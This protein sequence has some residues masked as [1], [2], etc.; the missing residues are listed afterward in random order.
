[1]E[2]TKAAP[3]YLPLTF[4]FAEEPPAAG[5]IE[6]QS[7][8][9][10]ECWVGLPPGRIGRATIEQT[11]A[12]SLPI[13]VGAFQGQET[14]FACIRRSKDAARRG[15]LYQRLIRAH[16]MPCNL[17]LEEQTVGAL[18]FGAG[19]GDLLLFDVAPRDVREA[20]LE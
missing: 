4:N 16:R 13:Y 17:Q 10:I 11:D 6:G 7:S 9:R 12:L 3:D 2:R 20:A 1:L 5:K 8:P 18:A 14:T 19:L 15:N